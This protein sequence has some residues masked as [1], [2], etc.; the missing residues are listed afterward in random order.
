M[1]DV[2]VSVQSIICPPMCI[3]FTSDNLNKFMDFI[4]KFVCALVLERSCNYVN[5]NE[6]ILVI[7]YRVMA[8]DK[9]LKIVFHAI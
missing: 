6:L 4:E 7:F 9:C 8:P 5:E 3:S 2:C 1:L